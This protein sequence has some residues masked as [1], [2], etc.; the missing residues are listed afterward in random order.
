M[1]TVKYPVHSGNHKFAVF[2]A[3]AVSQSLFGSIL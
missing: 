1:E 3:H 2:T